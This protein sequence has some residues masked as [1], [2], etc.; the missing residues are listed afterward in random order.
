[1]Y[2][3]HYMYDATNT[4]EQIKEKFKLNKYYYVIT[5]VNTIV[6]PFVYIKECESL[7]PNTKVLF[8]SRNIFSILRYI[9][10]YLWETKSR[11]SYPDEVYI[12]Y[13]FD[14][15][16]KYQIL[17]ETGSVINLYKLR[18]AL[19]KYLLDENLKFRT[20]ECLKRKAMQSNNHKQFAIRHTNNIPVVLSK[21]IYDIPTNTCIKHSYKFRS[22]PVPDISH[23]ICGDCCYRKLRMF[24]EIR[25][26]VDPDSEILIYV[27]GKRNFRKKFSWLDEI[28]RSTYEQTKSWKIQNKNRHQ[29]EK[30]KQNHVYKASE[31]KY[32]TEI[33]NDW[34][35][36]KPEGLN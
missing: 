27:R 31:D 12:E 15:S 28:S 24:N 14:I 9:A 2:W 32:I 30:H 11:Y 7:L 33:L 25:Q 22:D 35:I 19:Y 5:N 23:A 3:A 10:M 6:K 13:L 34:I 8:Y 26:N 1:L 18:H 29:W 36:E 16:N 20:R 4:K 21:E 17:D